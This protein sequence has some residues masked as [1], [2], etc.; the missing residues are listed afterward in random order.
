MNRF[1]GNGMN[2]VLRQTRPSFVPFDEH[3]A[4][5]IYRRNLPHWRQDGA[6]YFVTFRLGDSLPQGVVRAW[7]HEKKCWLGAR[8]IRCDG[9]RGKWRTKFEELP[10]KDQRQFYKYFNRKFHAALDKCHGACYLSDPR[11]RQAV[12]E[13]LAENDRVTYHLGDYILMPNH[14]HLL[15]TS[16]AGQELEA[17]MKSIKGASARYCN[18]AL[19]RRGTF[20]QADSYD[21]IV[22]TMD[23]LAAF[24][25]YISANPEK[26][27]IQ[28]ADDAIH[29]ANWI[30]EWF[31]RRTEFIPFSPKV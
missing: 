29:R 10:E 12:R 8:G 11:C 20:W 23:E 7:E 15:I 18:L 31:P 26:A 17:I 21:H 22:R 16:S 28:V 13:R 9:E 27:S 25:E 30:D 24:R 4:V 3:K 2:S 5:R 1:G 19:V 14:E 6:T